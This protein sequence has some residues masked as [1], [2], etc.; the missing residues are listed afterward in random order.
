FRLMTTGKLKGDLR[1]KMQLGLMQKHEYKLS[2]SVQ[3]QP[4]QH[5]ESSSNNFDSGCHNV[6]LLK[7]VFLMQSRAR[8]HLS[9]TKFQRVVNY[10]AEESD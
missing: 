1:E 3:A 10:N 6:M 4:F 2:V 8:Y 9:S 5:A 7:D